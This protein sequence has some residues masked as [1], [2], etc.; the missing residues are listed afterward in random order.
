MAENQAAGA[1][2]SIRVF[3][4]Y[5]HESAFEG[6]NDPDRGLGVNAEGYAI[7]QDLY[8]HGNNSRKY[9][10]VGFR[11][12][13]GSAVPRVLRAFT[14]YDLPRQYPEMLE[15][16][17]VRPEVPE[18]KFPA[19]SLSVPGTSSP[20]FTDQAEITEYMTPDSYPLRRLAPADGI[21]VSRIINSFQDTGVMTVWVACR[22]A[23]QYLLVSA[24]VFHVRTRSSAVD[25]TRNQE[26]G[27]LHRHDHT[28]RADL[29]DRQP[30]GQHHVPDLRWTAGLDP[31][32][33]AIRTR[34]AAGPAPAQGDADQ[35]S[36][37]PQGHEHDRYSGRPAARSR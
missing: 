19:R 29:H 16:I 22:G 20:G 1:A 2:E 9:I 28:G 3:I 8:D 35:G 33:P 12:S 37:R 23:V 31:A 36:G 26:R 32:Q 14:Y 10:P 30:V 13:W 25:R 17:L 6:H 21:F 5:S 11:T 7:T 27:F 34:K 4:S 15:R 18:I 24:R